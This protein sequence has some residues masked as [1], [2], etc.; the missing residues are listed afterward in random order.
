MPAEYIKSFVAD[1]AVRGYRI[2]AFH[3]SKQAA[4]EGASNTAVLIGVSTSTG[5]SARGPLDVVQVGPAEVVV[6]GNLSRGAFVTSDSQ[7]RAVALPAPGAEA[8]TVSVIGQVQVAAVEGDI[9]PINVAPFLLYIP[10][11]G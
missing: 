5:A 3:A 4:I 8:V 1:A 7:G 6:G 11:S 9:A 2:V 10:A